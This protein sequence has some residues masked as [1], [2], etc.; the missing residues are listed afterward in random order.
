MWLWRTLIVICVFFHLTQTFYFMLIYYYPQL[1]LKTVFKGRKRK[2][3]RKIVIGQAY[4]A[5]TPRYAS[6]LL[7]FHAFTGC[8]I[9][10]KF[11]GISKQH[12][13]KQFLNCSQHE[14]EAFSSLGNCKSLPSDTVILHLQ[15][16]IMKLYCKKNLP[17]VTNLGDLRWYLFRKC[18]KDIENLPPTEP[19]LC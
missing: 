13:W 1:C 17:D 16:F 4:Q 15:Q 11:N 12:C 3:L 2:D 5:I 9:T 6:A 8:N 18:E 19:S 14:F 7:G 10:G